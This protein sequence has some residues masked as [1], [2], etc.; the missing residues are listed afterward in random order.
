MLA[1]GVWVPDRNVGDCGARRLV[2]KFMD[3]F[4]AGFEDAARVAFRD[5]VTA[6]FGA[7]A[8]AFL[9]VDAADVAPPNASQ[10]NETAPSP[11]YGV[12][13]LPRESNS[14]PVPP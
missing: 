6:R 14:G 3:D 8:R 11:L 2:K 13:E 9:G 7:S 12:C 10:R 1:L 4:H 5:Y